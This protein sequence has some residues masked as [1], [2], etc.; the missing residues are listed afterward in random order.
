MRLVFVFLIVSFLFCTKKEAL[1]HLAIMILVILF[2]S[3]NELIPDTI[4]YMDLYKSP[5]SYLSSEI[6]FRYICHFFNEV[7]GLSFSWFLAVLALFSL[8]TFY[9]TSKRLFK[10]YRTGI[11]AVLM[12]SYFGFFYY[13]IVLRN[14]LAITICYSATPL[15]LGVKDYKP[16]VRISRLLSFLC[17]VAVAFTIHEAAIIFIILPF[18][19]YP[20][21][22]Y[23]KFVLLSLSAVLLFVGTI[24]PIYSF[25]TSIILDNEVARMGSYLQRDLSS[26]WAGVLQWFY[27]IFGFIFTFDEKRYIFHNPDDKDR[28]ALFSN[29]F[30]IGVLINSAL[31]QMDVAARF[32]MQFLYFDFILFYIFIFR[33]K[34]FVSHSIKIALLLVICIMQFYSLIHFVPLLLNY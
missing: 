23:I 11:L 1:H 8:E 24:T 5:D 13:G 25:I 15:L 3:R 22:R 18:L 31:W 6:G 29:I 17:I 26:D 34:R 27:V 33:N 12:L 14:S 32:A 20:I 7:L 21:P 9:L 28:Y 30:I 19:V 2:S 10:S 16:I 4:S